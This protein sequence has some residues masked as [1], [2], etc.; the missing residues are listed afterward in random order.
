MMKKKKIEI[1]SGP[2][3]LGRYV[4]FLTWLDDYFPGH[5]EGEY[6]T[7]ERGQIFHAPLPED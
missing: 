5:P 1:L 3:S 2:D 4:Y 6:V 7:R